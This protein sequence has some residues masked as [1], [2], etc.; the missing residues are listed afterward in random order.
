MVNNSPHLTLTSFELIQ[1]GHYM[2]DIIVL[3]IDP[4]PAKDTIIFDGKEFAKPV[5]S[6]LREWLYKKQEEFNDKKILICWDAPLTA[7]IHGKDK[8]F[9]TRPLEHTIKYKM[10][11]SKP[12]PGIH[13][14]AYALCP[15]WVITQYCLGL[16]NVHIESMVKFPF[17]L[18][19]QDEQKKKI[20]HCVVEVH[21]ALAIYAWL[22]DCGITNW[23]YKGGA[24]TAE[25]EERYKNL[26]NV[27]IPELFKKLKTLDTQL[28]DKIDMLKSYL[29]EK[30]NHGKDLPDLTIKE[31]EYA[32]DY[33][34]AFIAWLLGKLW[35]EDKEVILIGNED[36]GAILLPNTEWTKTLYE[37]LIKF[38]NGK[39]T[40]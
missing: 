24:K 18:I 32:A 27:F 2:E 20:A 34:D 17:E 13:T 3:G 28:S 4:A 39:M 8:D 23:Q 15:H 19:T 29:L 38:K 22:Q 33:L 30:I 12:P 9:Y 6:E 5:A 31:I 1:E 36:D 21:P 25:K 10:N 11:S 26:I 37:E 7:N 40:T 35:I 16:P 14:A